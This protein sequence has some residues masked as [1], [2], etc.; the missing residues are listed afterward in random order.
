MLFLPV[1]VYFLLTFFSS[2]I[3]SRIDRPSYL[4]VFA[5]LR[6]VSNLIPVQELPVSIFEPKKS[7]SL[8]LIFTNKIA[9]TDYVSSNRKDSPPR[10]NKRKTSEAPR[11]WLNLRDRVF[12]IPDADHNQ[13]RNPPLAGKSRIKD[14][15]Y[16]FASRQNWNTFDDFSENS[17]WS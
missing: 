16:S 7:Q 5:N 8:F 3:R 14:E 9:T 1:P 2:T 15:P 10:K 4:V 6:L 13:C 17:E 12:R 11:F